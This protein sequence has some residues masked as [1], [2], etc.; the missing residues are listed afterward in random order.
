MKNN[1][2]A[3]IS[4]LLAC[5]F[6][7]AQPTAPSGKKWQKVDNLS[8]EFN[9]NFDNN[10]WQK[11]LWDYTNTPTKMI[12][13]NSGVSQGNLWIKATL[14]PEPL[15]FQSS[16]I[17]SKAQIKFPM[18]T[19]SRM[20]TAHLSAYNTFWLNN[21]DINNRDEIDIVEN[22]SRP[23][24]GCQPNFP[25]Q[26]NSQYFQVINGNTERNKGNFDNRNLSPNN[27]KKGVRWNEEYHIVGMWWKDAN[28]VQ[29]YLDGEPAGSVKTNRPLTRNLNLIWDLWTDDENF[30]GGVAVKSHLNDNTINTMKVDWVHTYKLVNDNDGGN[31][32]NSYVIK[33]VKSN[34]WISPINGTSNNGAK[35]VNH[36]N[37]TGNA[38]EWTF[39]DKGDGY[40]EI[41]NIR[42][43]RCLAVAGGNPANGTKII[44]WDCKG[45]QDQQ[46]KRVDRGNGLFAFQNR[47]TGKCID[48]PAGNIAHNVQFQQWDCGA[49]NQN[50]RFWILSPGKLSSHDIGFESNESASLGSFTFPN[51]TKG[52]LTIPKL[53]KGIH[54]LKVIDMYGKVLL[55]HKVKSGG[56]D[57]ILNVDSLNPGMYTLLI[58]DESIKFLKE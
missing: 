46:W 58:D 31:T 1:L 7:Y 47:K 14:G 4:L 30:L 42:S 56:D 23:S 53:P 15:W 32:D 6:G 51:P 8:D 27:P 12:E 2:I 35:V 18:Y 20:I 29:F 24:C 17:Y 52:T 11:V 55:E 39:V 21:G 13:E 50:Q 57:V 19:E 3:S 22:N 28:N 25:W 5:F 49:S 9:G 16:R 54:S 43:G 10:K 41:K 45:Y 38:R 48:L 44:Q 26:M 40:S 37:G 36:Q 33:S 34:K